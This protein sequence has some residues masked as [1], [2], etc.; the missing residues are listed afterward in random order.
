MWEANFGSINGTIAGCFDERQVI[1]I[2]GM[3]DDVIDGLLFH[4]NRGKF[5]LINKARYLDRIHGW[6]D[7]GGA[8][9]ARTGKER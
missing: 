2:L 1:G 9:T 7:Y 4:V 6:H 5:A 8:H 3:E